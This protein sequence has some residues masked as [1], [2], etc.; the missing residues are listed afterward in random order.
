VHHSRLRLT[1]SSVIDIPAVSDFRESAPLQHTNWMP[2]QGF[3]LSPRFSRYLDF[4]RVNLIDAVTDAAQRLALDTEVLVRPIGSLSY[5]YDPAAPTGEC[6]TWDLVRDI[7]IWVYLS[8]ASIGQAPW[9]ALHDDML[10]QLRSVLE[11]RQVW[12]DRSERTGYLY[13]RDESGHRRL[14]EVKLARFDWLRDGLTVAHRRQTHLFRGPRPAHFDSPRREWAAHTPHENY[15]GTPAG[16]RRLAE[17]LAFIPASLLLR[18]LHYT[19]GENLAEAYRALTPYRLLRAGYDRRL[20]FRYARKVRKKQLM[21][22]VLQG[23]HAQRMRYRS[24]LLALQTGEGV[25]FEARL[26]QR[27]MAGLAEELLRMSE[28]PVSRLAHW[29]ARESSAPGLIPGQRPG[30]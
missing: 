3:D 6:V 5:S 7:D 28:L 21:L 13:L 24:E 17:Q 23:D 2:K 18:G 12:V 20:F 29:C 1:K 19:Y 9:R 30:G 27:Y 16:Y 10:V 8:D 15:Y 11:E 26:R 25:A 22:A 14:I 4:P